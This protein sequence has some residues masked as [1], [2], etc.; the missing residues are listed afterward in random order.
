[1]IL[2]GKNKEALKFYKKAFENS[3]YSAGPTQVTVMKEVLVL[4]A[5]CQDRVFL[6]KL[7]NQMIA[8]GLQTEVADNQS[9][10]SDINN[11]K[12]RAEDPIVEDWEVVQ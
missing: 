3:L 8:F 5:R 10:Y 9:K 11:A 4:A 2:S 7:K 6:K 1:M 12:S